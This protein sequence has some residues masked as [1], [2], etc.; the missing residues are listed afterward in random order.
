MPSTL[1]LAGNTS[2][3]LKLPQFIQFIK[4]KL[5]LTPKE[6]MDKLNVKSLNG[7]NLREAFEQLQQMANR[8]DS[9]AA[10]GEQQPGITE[11]ASS[12]PDAK[13]PAVRAEE[14]H[15]PAEAQ[16]ARPVPSAP[17]PLTNKMGPDILEI[18]HAVV[19]EIPPGPAFD[20]ELD[21]EEFSR[22]EDEEFPSALT[23][24][25]QHFAEDKLSSLREARGSAAAS[26]QR[27]KAL[28][29]VIDSQL[30]E[31]QLRELVQSVWGVS[32]DN[33]LK[34]EQVEALISWAKQDAFVEE[35]EVVLALLQENTYARSDR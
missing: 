27:L 11:S 22:D 8:E 35:V 21:D 3:S 16:L 24:H 2:E 1:G 32:V 7:V 5:N 30:S 13:K 19:R 18:K 34:N 10:P 17:I 12:R 31:E 33:K 20:E 29:N 26:Q 25:N 15:I 6:A 14:E 9:H 23:E 4:E 28:H